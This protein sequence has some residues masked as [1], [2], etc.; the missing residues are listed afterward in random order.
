MATTMQTAESS[1]EVKMPPEQ[2]HKKWLEWTGEGGPGMPQG[3]SAEV[4]TGKMDPELQKSEKGMAYFE[5]GGEGATKVR[6]QL[7]FNPEVIKNEGLDQDWVSRRINLY[8]SRFK[9][10]A[11][12]RAA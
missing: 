12:G 7:R 4:D 3:G 11:E 8:L 9:N 6:M 10:F 2:V 5:P 1:V